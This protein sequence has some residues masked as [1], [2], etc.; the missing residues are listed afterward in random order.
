MAGR[1]NEKNYYVNSIALERSSW[2]TQ[3]F[4]DDMRDHHQSELP[5]KFA[6]NIIGE[7]YI[8][9]RKLEQHGIVFTGNAPIATVATASNSNGHSN[10]SNG[11]RSKATAMEETETEGQ[12][13]S[14]DGG[15]GN[16]A[17]F[18]SNM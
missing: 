18:W 3:A 16:V 9:K 2:T 1:D 17:D 12:D 6:A 10:G 5:G 7:Y 11:R 4:L 8:L 15:L 13:D 14:D